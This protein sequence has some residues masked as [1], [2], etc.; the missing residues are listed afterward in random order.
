MK[1]TF[2]ET[3]ADFRRWLHAHHGK[4]TA[5]LVGFHK[6]A[7]RRA[8]MTYQEALDEALAVGWIDGV[9]RS[10]GPGAYTIR[11]TPRKK[12][13][14]WS[15]V[16]TKR[17]GVLIKA[18]RMKAPGLEAFRERDPEKTRKYSYER[19]HLTLD[20]RS[21]RALRADKKAYTFFNAQPPG[22][23]R[24]AIFWIMSAKREDT[25]AR[26]LAHLIERSRAGGRIGLLSPGSRT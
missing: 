21:L 24:I 8:G 22:Y 17:V 10:H 23:K 14:F 1:A 11:F 20:A 4:T 15:V 12:G 7:S 5:L 3:A 9:R 26:R 6:K 19:E 18:G 25:R 13:S 2:F 16:N